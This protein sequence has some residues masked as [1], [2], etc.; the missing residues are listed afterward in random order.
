MKRKYFVTDTY[1]QKKIH[2][3]KKKYIH[4]SRNIDA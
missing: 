4:L 2:H 3:I 1:W